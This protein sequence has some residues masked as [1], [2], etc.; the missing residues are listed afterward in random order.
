MIEKDSQSAPPVPTLAKFFQRH[1]RVRAIT[2]VEDV[3]TQVR[4]SSANACRPPIDSLERYLMLFAA[5]I[6]SVRR[7]HA[8]QVAG[9]AAV[10]I[11]AAAFIGWWVSLPLPWSWGTNFASVKPT[12]ALCISA[13]GLALALD[14]PGRERAGAR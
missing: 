12:T 13:L 14:L 5:L 9:F 7:Q 1:S 2:Y 10:A 6:G 4:A 8:S 3:A 11:G